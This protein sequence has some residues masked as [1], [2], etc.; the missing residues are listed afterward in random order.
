MVGGHAGSVQSNGEH[1]IKALQS[2]ARGLTE[3]EFYKQVQRRCTR[4]HAH[5]C[6]LQA[7][8]PQF[9]GVVLRPHQPASPPPVQAL[10]TSHASRSWGSVWG[11]SAPTLKDTGVQDGQ[12][13]YIQLEDVTLGM[14]APCVCDMKIGTR[15]WGPAASRRKQDRAI[16]R[17]PTQLV[18][19]YRFTGMRTFRPH[20]ASGATW[21]QYARDYGKNLALHAL[22]DGWT[23][24]LWDGATFRHEVADEI[25]AQLHQMLAWFEAQRDWHFFSSS[26]LIAFDGAWKPGQGKP[27][28]R[29]KLIDFSHAANARGKPDLSV[30]VGLRNAIQALQA[31]A[32]EHARPRLSPGRVPVTEPPA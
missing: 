26:V 1:V 12:A 8:V 23:A 29:V 20:D 10:G 19:G 16:S 25:I 27:P 32:S 3:V 4:G 30:A 22:P 7:L 15:S 28:V 17:Y 6:Q 11:P 18:A 2:G 9:H 21:A 13:A 24:F 14:A 31:A 5:S